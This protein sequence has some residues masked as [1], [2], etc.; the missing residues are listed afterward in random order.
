MNALK[1]SELGPLDSYH[2]NHPSEM[3]QKE[4]QRLRESAEE[5]A[6][7]VSDGSGGDSEREGGDSEGGNGD[8]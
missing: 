5:A 4:R 1:D 3:F 7:G 2:E 6:D 8:T